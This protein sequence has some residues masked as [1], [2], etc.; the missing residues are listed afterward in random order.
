MS[1]AAPAAPSPVRSPGGEATYERIVAEA[2]NLF[3]TQGYEGT[4]MSRVAKAAGVT[5]PALYWHFGSKEEL[6]FTAVKQGY[7][8]FRDALLTRAIGG[9]AEDR[10]RRFVRVFVKLQL[11]DPDLSMKYGYHQ[12]R[13]ALPDAKRAEV[14]AMDAEWK[15]LLREILLAGEEEG[16]FTFDNVDVTTTALGSMLE[17][18]F[19]WFK[20]D[21]RLSVNDVADLYV[22]LARRIAGAD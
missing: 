6:Y 17:Y 10:F 9:C 22:Q 16:V 18:V 5:T 13:D 3:A 19:I 20:A 12:L 15:Q 7:V 4:P 1:D 8:A 2:M 14:D 11:Q 21:G